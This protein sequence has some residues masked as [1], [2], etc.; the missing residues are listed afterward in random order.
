[1]AINISEQFI[2]NVALPVDSRIVASN[3][4][5][6]DAIVFKYDGLRVF[7]QD[8]RKTYIWNESSSTWTLA[9]LSGNGDANYVARW[10]SEIG[11]TSSPLYV[12]NGISNV[13]GKIG[14]NTNSPESELQISGDGG[15]S[16][17]FV[18]KKDSGTILGHNWYND[19][20]DNFFLNN[21]GS[22]AIKFRSNGEI[23]IL[24][25][26]GGNAALNSFDGNF[27]NAVA[28]FS[29]N[30]IYLTK[31]TI[32]GDN[33]SSSCAVIRAQ[34]S[35]STDTTPDYT[36]FQNDNTGFFHPS[37]N[38]IGITVAGTR[39]A[40][41]SLTGLLLSQNTSITGPAARLHLDSGNGVTV[42]L[43]FTSGTITGTGVNN[44]FNVGINSSGYPVLASRHNNFPFLFAFANGNIGGNTYHSI[45]RNERIIYSNP[46]GS[47]F[48][49]LENISRYIEG[50]KRVEFSGIATHIIATFSVPND[51]QI[52]VDS[53]FISHINTNPIQLRTNRVVQ[54][55]RVDS[56]GIISANNTG[57]NLSSNSGYSVYSLSS[58][59]SAAIFNG[60]V[61]IS[62][63]NI[64]IFEQQVTQN[65][66]GSLM[67][68]Y[69]INI[70]LFIQN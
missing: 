56:S 57:G 30:S 20:S 63:P 27:T 33:T 28:V 19:G 2:V 43:K 37:I 50:S 14:I 54:H 36:W 3:S 59:S 4:T 7:L 47:T 42:F 39:R 35:F 34:N 9:E 31:S 21:E 55:F 29:L 41:I 62:N 6:R 38:V 40:I 1:M 48:A 58:S 18:V 10:S 70:N 23:S 26:I 46:D 16:Q 60:I 32:F 15:T 22:G 67:V 13:S 65:A 25:R 69:E 45:K 12:I 52:S 8:E 68:K 5:D 49:N 44:G 53:V 24:S 61:R 17:P 66:S 11:L 64:L 51:S